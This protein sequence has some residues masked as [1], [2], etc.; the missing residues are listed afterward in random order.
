MHPGKTK[1]FGVPM[2]R[3]G[4]R[5]E[6]STLFDRD[7]GYPAKRP[8]YP[9]AKEM[10]Q[11]VIPA[12]EAGYPY[13]LKALW[14]HM[15]TPVY[16]VPGGPA[17]QSRILRDPQRGNPAVGGRRCTRGYSRKRGAMRAGSGQRLRADGQGTDVQRAPNPLETT[18]S[19]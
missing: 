4:W 19:E 9:F 7:G 11:D 15:G 16:A 17:E 18:V 12:V 13:P 1:S 3:E 5:Y 14:I 6:D 2:T 8:W 10:Y